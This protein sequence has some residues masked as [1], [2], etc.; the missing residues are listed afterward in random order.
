VC[1]STEKKIS[2]CLQLLPSGQLTANNNSFSE[3]NLNQLNGHLGVG[4]GCGS[5]AAAAPAGNGLSGGVYLN[6]SLSSNSEDLLIENLLEKKQKKL[7]EVQL[8]QTL[9][10]LSDLFPPDSSILG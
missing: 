2:A 6:A 9:Q 1:Q 8:H 10:E 4:G 7:P 3:R 5:A